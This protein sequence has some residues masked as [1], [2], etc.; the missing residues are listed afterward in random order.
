MS[1]SVVLYRGAQKGPHLTGALVR[2][3]L[4]ALPA[5]GFAA[6]GAEPG[7]N[8]R[9]A[10][11]SVASHAKLPKV[12]I[13]APRE[14]RAKV[15]RFVTSVA[16]QPWGDSLYRWTRPICPLVA[17]L[18]K[19]Q[20]EFVLA[21][22]SKTAT[23]AHAP[24]AGRDCRPN[25]FVVGV[26]GDPSPFLKTWW[27]HARQL[28][29]F[30]TQRIEAVQHFIDSTRPIRVWYNT[31]VGCNDDAAATST[32]AY[33]I[34]AGVY[35]AQQSPMG[36]GSTLGSRIV[37]MSTGSDISSAMIVVDGRQMKNVNLGQMAD[38]IALVGLADVRV[39]ADSTPVPSILELFG[40]G[41]PPQG[42]TRWD[43]ALLYSLYNTS[44][45]STL[46][47]P[48]MEISM[49]RHMAP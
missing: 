43:R 7:S 36:C 24:L 30:R 39:D 9:S 25:L 22:I 42:L 45:R 41:E 28:Y 35:H 15:D 16:I 8:T 23:D 1:G 34:M 4:I 49:T 20:G 19:T 33:V 6:Q 5:L 18:P 29:S 26:D 21:R 3:L 38:Y 11:A 17:G 40:H 13:Q 27:A 46:E 37:S 31:Y 44:H 47:L 14:L 48:E 12:T 32:L 10:Q 2:L